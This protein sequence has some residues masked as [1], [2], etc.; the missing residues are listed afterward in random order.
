MNKTLPDVITAILINH[1]AIVE[2]K[3]D[4]CLDVIA[5]VKVS[6]ILNM[7]EYARLSFSYGETCD[8]AIYASYD[9]EF[10]SLIKNLFAGKGRFT[11]AYFE[12]YA[13]NI[14]K[15]SKVIPEKVAFRNATFRLDRTETV[16]LSYLLVYFKYTA[17][18]D[19]KR[20]GILPLLINQLNLSIKPFQNSIDE[21]MEGLKEQDSDQ[22]S[23]H[24]TNNLPLLP[25]RK[26]GVGRFEKGGMGKIKVLQSAHTA[27]TWMVQERLKD[28]IKSLER[29][30]NRDIK[31]VYEYYEAL[32]KE[33]KRAIE[34]KIIPEETDD[35][36]TIVQGIQDYK[37]N[38]PKRYV[39]QCLEKIE[40]YD[41]K[42][43]TL[44]EKQIEDG[45]TR[46]EGI[47]KLLHKLDAIEAE[48]KWKI[49]DSIAK[50]ALSIQ[51]DP[52]AVINIEMHAPVFWINIKRRLASRQFPVT[53][54]PVVRQFDALPCESCFNPYGGYYICDD[55]LHIVCSN[56]F[57]ACPHCGKQ[58]CRACHKDICPKCKKV[59]NEKEATSSALPPENS[60][61]R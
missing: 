59:V 30:L 33:T 29:R 20:E 38:D 52:V 49:Q 3:E 43:K 60:T 24:P 58:Y 6:G 36:N 13:P 50:Y 61:I 53:Y 42:G 41:L 17:L 28:F 56:C 26:E 9:S 12:P 15:I 23:P 34:K 2:R 57:K 5:P 22:Q 19:E 8:E 1:G 48:R 54:N 32:K 27:A 21:L 18:S 55:N 47:D 46:G 4:G 7:P 31:R 16:T 25:F 51:I 40:P 37:G 14:E 10:F 35:I 11:H 45:T 39:L 44:L